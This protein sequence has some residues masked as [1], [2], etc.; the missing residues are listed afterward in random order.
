M[1]KAKRVGILT[2]GG[3][4]GGL[5]AVIRAVVRRAREWDMEVYGIKGATQGL[6]SR[7][8]E[9]ELLDMKRV[10]GILRYGGTILGTVNKGNPFAYPLSDGET[11]DR[12]QEVIDGYHQLGL[13]ALIGIGGDGSLA[14]LRRLAQQGNMNLVAVPKTIDND[15]GA[16]ENSIGFNTAVSVAVEAL[17]RLTYTAISHS[18]VM[19]LEVMGRDAGHIAVS[20]GIAGG[21]HVILIPE[22]PYDLDK[23]CDRLMNRALRGFN[24]STMVV[25]EAVKTPSGEP[26]RYTNSLGQTLY[27]GI[28]QY[29]GDQISTRTNMESRVTILGHVQRGSTPSPLDRILGAAFGVAAVDLVAHKQYDRMVAWINREVISVPISE[30]IAQYRAVDVQGTLIRT[31]LGLGT[32]IGEI[33]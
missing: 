33:D 12:S 15:L 22:I 8:V 20:A 19:I 18:R 1:S 26:V 6:M 10:S 29:L 2:S 13:D 9:S 21:A 32:Y 4:C 23:V 24:F 5:N 30:A 11:I 16:T 27:G 31:A 28:G 17:D 3:D 7:P 14:I 25:A